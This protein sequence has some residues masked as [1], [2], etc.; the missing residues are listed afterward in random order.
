MVGAAWKVLFE[1][2]LFITG[3]AVLAV[4]SRRRR[5]YMRR[6][7]IFLARDLLQVNENHDEVVHDADEV[8]APDPL[9]FF[10]VLE[11]PL[12]LFRDLPDDR[13][14]DDVDEVH[15][16]D[17]QQVGVARREFPPRFLGVPLQ[18][19]LE[20][21]ARNNGTA[22]QDEHDEGEEGH[23]ESSQIQES[24]LAFGPRLHFLELGQL[25]Q[26]LGRFLKNV[27]L[28]PAFVGDIL[29]IP[30]DEAAE[31]M[32]RHPG[33]SLGN[34]VELDVLAAAEEHGLGLV[35]EVEDHGAEDAVGV[36]TAVVGADAGVVEDAWD[37]VVGGGV[38]HF[39]LFSLYGYC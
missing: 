33:G 16:Q 9:V 39:K 12:F 24:P 19:V 13:W 36:G 3:L 28:E 23:Q 4:R 5:I 7:E 15:G 32:E 34:D 2:L 18:F 14:N 37:V 21:G 6:V 25:L 22:P 17:R 38:A 30:V 29:E 8:D 20:N 35:G 27:L 1:F 11:L 10:P 26:E 31:E